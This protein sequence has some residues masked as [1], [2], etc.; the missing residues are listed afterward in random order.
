MVI[1]ADPPHV[2]YRKAVAMDNIEET[3]VVAPASTNSR[4]LTAK[5]AREELAIICA[6]TGPVGTGPGGVRVR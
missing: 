6:C 4:R 5:P 3:G 1:F 2:G